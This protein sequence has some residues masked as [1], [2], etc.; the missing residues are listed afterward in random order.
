MCILCDQVR[1]GPGGLMP[2]IEVYVLKLQLWQKCKASGTAT[3]VV[4]SP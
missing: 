2:L 3:L 1:G 4:E